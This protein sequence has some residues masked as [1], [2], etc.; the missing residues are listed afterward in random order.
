MATYSNRIYGRIKDGV[1]FFIFPYLINDE[2][3]RY[4]FSIIDLNEEQFTYSSTEIYDP[5]TGYTKD[6]WV[7]D[8]PNF[9]GLSSDEDGNMYCILRSEND[10]KDYLWRFDNTPEHSYFKLAEISVSLGLDRNTDSSTKEP[11]NLEKGFGL[12]SNNELIVY[13]IPR[14]FSGK[15]RKIADFSKNSNLTGYSIKAITDHHV[16]FSDD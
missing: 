1:Y 9:W 5:S 10:N 3:T 12:G 6:L 11:F 13:Q 7:N 16:F 15:L 8:E 4:S 2:I 14:K